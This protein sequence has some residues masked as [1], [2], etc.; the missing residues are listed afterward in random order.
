MERLEKRRIP[1]KTEKGRGHE[2]CKRKQCK[3]MLLLREKART[4][5]LLKADDAPRPGPNFDNILEDYGYRLEDSRRLGR[6]E[7]MIKRIQEQGNC[8]GI[9][10]KGTVTSFVIEEFENPKPFPKPKDQATRAV[11]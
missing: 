11:A 2:G 1:E 6:V 9:E 7:R 3:L 5:D 10:T 8:E 4:E